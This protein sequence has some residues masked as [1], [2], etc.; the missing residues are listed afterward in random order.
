VLKFLARERQA[1]SGDSKSVLRLAVDPEC[2]T[3]L[4]CTEPA[5]LPENNSFGPCGSGSLREQPPA[6]RPIHNSKLF[7]RAVVDHSRVRASGMRGDRYEW[8][9]I[10]AFTHKP[11]PRQTKTTDPGLR[12]S[13]CLG[14]PAG[15]IAPPPLCF[16]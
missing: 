13:G 7:K 5:T 3:T 15:V 1:P 8:D 9:L 11:K 2:S 12:G 10:A 14:S 6:D 16:E 4:S